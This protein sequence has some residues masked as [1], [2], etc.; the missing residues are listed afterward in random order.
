MSQESTWFREPISVLLVSATLNEGGGQ[1]FTSTVVEHFDRTLVL[2]TLCLQ[3]GDIGFHLPAD[4]PVR[5]LGY[6]R[7]WHL[8]LAVRRLRTLI[9][10]LRPDVVLSNLSA[11]GL[12]TGL[13]LRRSRHQPAWV[14]RIGGSPK[15]HDNGL[16]KAV[17]RVVYP[18]ADRFVTIAKNMVAGLNE[19]YPFTE[20]RTS[21]IYNPTDFERIEREASLAP[22]FV[23]GTREP[24]LIAVGR[25]FRQ[26]RH[27]VLIRAFSKVL[28]SQPVSLWICGEGPWRK[29]LIGLIRSLGLQQHVRLL[30]FCPNPYA[31]MRQATLF[32]MSSD[33]EGLGNAIIEAQGLG[34]PAISTR[35]PYGPD[36]VIDDGRTGILV[37]MG[38]AHSLA[39]AIRELLRDVPRCE[40]MGRDARLHVR[41]RFAVG[42]LT[43][44][45]EDLLTRA[46]CAPGVDRTATA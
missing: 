36:E 39:D 7:P 45:W 43:R 34:L 14:A 25:L 3:K 16:R 1:R 41:E 13:A 29:R 18:R 30:G 44:E 33:W 10:E 19:V 17:A 8:P 12:L 42:P 11:T 38:D 20:G 22:Q 21:V 4:V 40:Q 6:Q 24:L 27:D 35:C 31:L 28:A 23:H 9:E 32:L 2:P 15:H 37:P 26:K 5:V 46:S